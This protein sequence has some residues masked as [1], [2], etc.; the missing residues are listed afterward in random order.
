M[1]VSRP[2]LNIK[3]IGYFGHCNLGD[4]QYL[5]S[6][7]E[8]LTIFMPSEQS[9]TLEFYDCDKI[10]QYNFSQDD[11]IIIGGG[12]VLNNYFLD[13]IASKF[14]G[15]KNKI[16]AVSVG[17]P[18]KSTL[19]STNK[20][21]IIDY[22]F[23]R[24]LQ[25]VQLF[26]NYFHPHRVCYLPDISYILNNIDV[27]QE[28]DLPILDQYYINR[29]DNIK[30]KY[31]K[32]IC[33]S[34]SMH[35]Y[36]KDYPNEYINVINKLG[37]FFEN[38]VTQCNYHLVFLP[39][40]DNLKN[41]G[42]NDLLIHRDVINKIMEIN[43]NVNFS[44]ITFIE[45]VLHYNQIFQLLKYVNYY[46][47]TRFHACLFSIY[48]NTPFLPIYTTRKISNLLKDIDWKYGYEMMMNE[49]FIPT[50]ISLNKL[51]EVFIKMT[52]DQET[53]FVLSNANNNIFSKYLYSN[54]N[55]LINVILDKS[56][57][58]SQHKSLID[59]RIDEVYTAVQKFV[60]T[61]GYSDFR[62]VIEQDLQN[63]IVSIVSYN[64]TK[65]IESPYNYGLMTKMFNESYNYI[66]EW[67][68][69]INHNEYKND[70]KSN[71]H[72][73][74]NLNYIDQVDYSG[75]HRSGW[76]YVYRNLTYLHND[77]S[78]VLLDLYLD[79]TFHWNANINEILGIIPYKQNWMGF[80]HHTFDVTFS[81][82][83]CYNLIASD[84]FI[85]SL[86]YCKALFVLS[87]DLKTKFETHFKSIGI[88]V[89]VFSFIHPTE[90]NVP[91]FTLEKFKENTDKKII[92][93]GGWLRNV[94]A[95]YN[96]NIP[97]TVSFSYG[98]WRFRKYKQETIRKVALK[99]KSNNNYFPLDDF[100]DKLHYAL[101]TKVVNYSNKNVSQNVSQNINGTTIKNNWYKHF[102][103]DVINKT[104]GIDCI[105]HLENEE[106]DDLLTKNIVCIILV[107]ASAI[108][109]LVECIVRNT[110]III[111][112]IAP[113][114]EL[115]GEKY[116]LYLNS[117]ATD[118]PGL[119]EEFQNMMRNPNKIKNAYK[120]L[121]K[122]DKTKF[123][124]N[125]FVNEFNNRIV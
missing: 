17:L 113:V 76:Q 64:L 122:M 98:F 70:L 106:Y 75:T 62:N 107:D 10:K 16:L 69:I 91:Q 102:Y 112:K 28:Q 55:T 83:N 8:I 41:D 114:V 1:K 25:D 57:N 77:K 81:D 6:F 47:A 4:E 85:Q 49:K 68:W 30:N 65:C 46:I 111:N 9:Y 43:N 23:V 19:T 36:N 39:F 52:Q 78:D 74:F 56:I 24:T 12:D 20:L 26:S 73:L 96:L 88:Y 95:F 104:K 32:I 99:G 100:Y 31:E 117:D 5:T 89:P 123:H 13:K 27:M 29:F 109:T 87:D 63:I 110:P 71:P 38:L 18:F 72:G 14:K 82:Y 119:N 15:A 22:V 40:N 60:Q 45:H 121:K 42:E 80:V 35:V 61:K 34:L 50:D 92:H 93:V 97:K 21:D 59:V 67:K 105:Y 37:A 115:L 103:Q 58:D 54:A 2:E 7:K 125:Y 48:S 120:Y 108:N 124:I 33:I 79:R 118:Y 3:V 86:K 66:E 94:Y 84:L 53:A 116:P 51:N 101:S 44:N 11:I 90:T